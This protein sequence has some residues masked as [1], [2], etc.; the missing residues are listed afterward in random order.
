[1]ID[2]YIKTEVEPFST[3]FFRFQNYYGLAI[4]QNIGNVD[5]MVAASKAIL[6]HSTA[7]HTP[8]YQLQIEAAD[9]IFAEEHP[10]RCKDSIFNHSCCPKTEEERHR[11]CPVGEDSWCKWQVD[12]VKGTTSYDATKTT[13]PHSFF[14]SLQDIFEK[15]SNRKLLA[16]CEHGC[17]QNAVRLLMRVGVLL[18]MTWIIVE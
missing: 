13:L 18:G 15:L 11:Y 1:M 4:R 6:Y 14:H 9:V 8:E 3:I 5:A 2:K 16:R 17:T 12:K 10:S 7:L